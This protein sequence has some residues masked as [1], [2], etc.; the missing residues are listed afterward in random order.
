[1]SHPE[2]HD[3]LCDL[4][5]RQ[6]SDITR[7]SVALKPGTELIGF[8]GIQKIDGVYDFGYYFRRSFS[9]KGYASEACTAVLN[10]IET[11]LNIHEF[12]I[13]IADAN[14]DSSRLIERLG[15][16]RGSEVVK[17][18]ESGAFYVRNTL[19]SKNEAHLISPDKP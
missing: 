4:L 12:Q 17:D 16:I 8:A 5:A 3:W 13:F 15:F 14:Y 10:H 19:S 1:M 18:G 11:V 9:G 7:Y 2:S 6:T